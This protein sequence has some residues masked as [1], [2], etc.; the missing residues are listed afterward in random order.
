MKSKTILT[1]IDCHLFS[2]FIRGKDFML[3]PSDE[4]KHIHQLREREGSFDACLPFDL[5]YKK[6]YVICLMECIL[7]NM[8]YVGKGYSTFNIRLNTQRNDSKEANSIL[9]YNHSFKNIIWTKHVKLIILNQ[10]VN[11]NGSKKA[12]RVVR[13]F[14]G[15]GNKKVFHVAAFSSNFG[16][17]KTAQL[18]NHW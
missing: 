4:S 16:S 10:L 8:Q 11:L 7:C 15:S 18:W 3:Q 14:L 6:E 12:L 2:M 5:N 13:K 9:A 1:C 17:P